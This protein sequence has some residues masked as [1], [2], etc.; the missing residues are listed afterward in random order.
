MSGRRHALVTGILGFCGQHLAADLLEAGYRVSGLDAADAPSP[1]QAE[2]CV[3]DIRDLPWLADVLA[4]LKP[5]HLFHLAALTNPQ[6]GW[7]GLYDVNVRGTV[8]LL[9]AVRIASLD[10]VIVVAGSSA[11][12]GAVRESELPIGEDQPF[13]P[14]NAYAVSKAAQELLAYSYYARFGQRVVRARPFN[15]TGPGEAPGFVV[16][17]FAQQ[18][19]R[20][21]A[22]LQ[23][24]IV[25]VGNLDSVR[26]FV[27]VRDTAR[28]Y[29]LLGE[30]G[31]PGEVYNICS[32]SATVI[33]QLL[34]ALL[35]LSHLTPIEVLPVASRMQPADV[36]VQVGS[37]ERL[38]RATAWQP[39]IDLHKTLS[40]ALESWRRKFPPR[41]ER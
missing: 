39:E 27:D 12:Y 10:P 33:R 31:R 13:R 41:S 19:A 26:D 34:E 1:H 20:I 40:D 32:G 11:V 22:G 37:A 9:E 3:G 14:R 18:I 28:A 21:E 36:P 5:T 23:A 29:R 17:A 15:L 4:R 24:P 25:E 35:S 16:S 38:R 7:D 2:V 8:Q 30:Q 6:A